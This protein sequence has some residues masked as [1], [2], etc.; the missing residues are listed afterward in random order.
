MLLGRFLDLNYIQVACLRIAFQHTVGKRHELKNK[1]AAFFPRETASHTA[2]CIHGNVACGSKL[3]SPP[4]AVGPCAFRKALLS[5]PLLVVEFLGIV[6]S[7]KRDV[8]HVRSQ[9]ELA[10]ASHPGAI[11]AHSFPLLIQQTQHVAH[12]PFESKRQSNEAPCAET[13]PTAQ[14]RPQTHEG[15]ATRHLLARQT[16]WSHS[17]LRGGLPKQVRFVAHSFETLLCTT[18]P[19]ITGEK[20]A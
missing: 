13:R 2:R 14:S 7:N 8:W 20:T 18:L 12:V 17:A 4:A 16:V 15:W 5:P 10:A 3:K 1:I 6:P 19:E 11:S 9:P